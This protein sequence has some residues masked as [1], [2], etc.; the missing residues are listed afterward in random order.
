[1]LWLKRRKPGCPMDHQSCGKDDGSER[2]GNAGPPA[3][4]Q[5]YSSRHQGSSICF[6]CTVVIS[7]SVF[8]GSFGLGGSGGCSVFLWCFGLGSS[9]GCSGVFAETFSSCRPSLS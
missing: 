8:V 9:G 3:R 1:M 5:L 7:T 6:F 2:L 4:L